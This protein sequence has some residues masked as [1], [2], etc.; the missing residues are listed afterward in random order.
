MTPKHALQRT[1]AIASL[2]QSS[3]RV[4]AVAELLSLGCFTRMRLPN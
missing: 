3:R 1:V 4:D 2:L